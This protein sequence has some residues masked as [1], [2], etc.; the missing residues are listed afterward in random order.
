MKKGCKIAGIVA[1]VLAGLLLAVALLVSPIAKGYVNK[2]GEKLVGRKIAVERLGVNIFTG[3]VKIGDLTLFEEDGETPFV[4]FD[5]LDT[6][7]RLISLIGKKVNVRHVTLANL[8]A[9]INQE[10][11]VFNFTSM[12]DHFKKPEEEK[13]TTPSDWVVA[14]YNINLSHWKVHYSDLQ[15]GNSWN[16][17]DLNLEV[18]GFVI[19][20]EDNTDAG[21][22]IALAEGGTLNTKLKYDPA[23]ND[24]DMA[25]TIDSV[26]LANARPYLTDVMH[27][28]TMEGALFADLAA[29]GNLSS[30]PATEI[31]GDVKLRN[32]DLR[33]ESQQPVASFEKLAVQANE[34]N[35]GT[36]IIDL[37][38]VEIAGLNSHFDRYAQG[39]NFGR[40]FVKKGTAKE[41]AAPAQEQPNKKADRK[42][43][44]KAKKSAKKEAKKN[45]A[46][47]AE[48]ADCATIQDTEP[49]ADAANSG[50][51][52]QKEKQ[53][54]AKPKLDLRMGRVDIHDAQFAYN[55][56]TLKERFSLPLTGIT[57]QAQNMRL[58]GENAATLKAQ[59]PHGG[60]MEVDWKGSL[61][62]FKS[63]QDL[64][65]VIRNLLLAD[66]SPYS[67]AY[68]GQPFTDGTFSFTSHNVIQ[69]SNIEGENHIDL[70]KPEAGARVA[71]ADS[72]LNIPLKAALYIL[73]DKNDRVQLDVPVAGNLDNPEFSYMKMVWKTLGNLCVKVATSP[74][75][76]AASALG[77]GSS[78]LEFL[79]FDPQQ[80]EFTS[81]Q[82]HVLGQLAAVAHYDTTI[83]FRLTQ[84]L[85]NPDSPEVAALAAAR[86]KKVL[87]H[88][89]GDLEVSPA[90]F[91]VDSI[92]QRGKKNGFA[93]E[94]HIPVPEP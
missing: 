20:G 9:T 3:R 74:A 1:A 54:S 91:E 57:I 35:F 37:G 58:Q 53:T 15:R 6:R 19:G 90:Q 5:E 2:N 44:K 13:D 93:I 56:L 51:E 18:P 77:F 69:N 32:V 33:D 43:D 21:L 66:M 64:T 83:T 89:M 14:L 27:I 10:G 48:Q 36:N 52:A 63:H 45:A 81:E 26:G 82:Y 17:K 73:K 25:L 46:S 85:A 92:P 31:S 70:Y 39:S 79:P 62:N 94:A 60:R 47:K 87:Q 78:N 71:D 86:R 41:E 24:F 4:A 38:L 65:L 42:A 7:V 12:L 84:Q 30:L 68:L 75:R 40:L 76:K 16:L 11:K 67:V 88:M 8:E 59:M 23:T 61:S 28:G 29:K 22:T 49:K 80:T 50:N 72:A 55:D 34:I